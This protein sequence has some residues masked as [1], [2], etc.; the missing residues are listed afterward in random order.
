[1]ETDRK[2]LLTRK[3]IFAILLYIGLI[4]LCCIVVY[5][6]P[7]VRGMLEK[8]YIA[9]YGS[10]DVTD[11]VSAF[12]VRDETV[13]AAGQKSM[14]NRLAETDKL[15]KAYTQIVELTPTDADLEMIDGSESDN[16]VIRGAWDALPKTEEE[17]APAEGEAAG[18]PEEK[19]RTGRYTKIMEDLGDNVVVT[20][21]GVAADSGYISYYVD[22]A[23]AKLSTDAIDSLTEKDIKSLT[24]RRAIEVPDK[25]C[26][27]GYPV[28]KVVRNSKWYLVYY[29]DNESAAKYYEGETVN[30]DINDEEVAVR[31]S[32]IESGTKTS[33]IVLSCKTFFPGFLEIRNLDTTVTINE[34]EGLVLDDSS[35]VTAPD[36]MRGVFVKNKLG[37]HVFKPVSAKA[38]NGKKCV[39][40]S[41]IYVDADGN[42]VETI[43]TYDEIVAEPT[44]EDIA[45]LEKSHPAKK[46]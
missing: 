2:G 12:I 32:R 25:H 33:K 11:E 15:I 42:F 26:G 17:P 43:R 4:A 37:E 14:I 10:I 7:S 8:T 1:M 22:G 20:K 13:Y 28:F 6:I 16:P 24:G 34:A 30:I 3:W 44:E 19:D 39:V 9:Q 5:A 29:L 27:K 31:V 45:G 23:E 36:G 40:F 21:D 18:E 46:P 41:D 38:D 35:I